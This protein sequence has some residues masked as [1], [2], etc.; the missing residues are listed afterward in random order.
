MWQVQEDEPNGQFDYLKRMGVDGIQAFRL[1]TWPAEVVEAYFDAAQQSGLKVVV[2][3][4][5]FREGIKADCR[6]SDEGLTFIRNYRLHP[7]IFAWHTLDEPAEHDISKACQRALYVAVK[8]LDP[9]RPIML[10]A[11]N[12]TSGK[13]RK[14]FDE[15]AFDILEM[16]KYVNPHISSKEKNLVKLFRE[17]RSRDYPV[18][19]TLRAFNAPHK[20]RRKAMVPGSLRDQYDFFVEQSGITPH[21]GLYGW[22]LAPN[23]GIRQLDDLRAEFES[24]MAERI[25]SNQ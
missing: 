15:S 18:I 8:E 25:L 24:F 7:A 20:P 11:N 12:N 19:I 13:Y 16:H 3:I 4:G 23:K 2:Y 22:D 6:Y 5:V 14:F 9:D 1:A 21:F 17:N 10:S